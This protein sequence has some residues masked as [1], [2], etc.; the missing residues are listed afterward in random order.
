MLSRRRVLLGGAALGLLGCGSPD[1]SN[2][3]TGSF[4]QP[5]PSPIPAT[6]SRLYV[7]NAGAGSRSGDQLRLTQLSSEV[8][9][10]DDRPARAAGRQSTLS[11]LQQWEQLGFVSDPPNAVFQVENLSFPVILGKPILDGPAQAVTFAIQPDTGAPSLDQLPTSFGNC[12]LFIDDAGSYQ[13]AMVLSLRF[14][15]SPGESIEV[16]L[17]ADQVPVSIGIGQPGV[18]SG[19]ILNA[20]APT[21]PAVVGLFFN[22]VLVSCP[23]AGNGAQFD[24]DLFVLAQPGIQT[25]RIVAQG[26]GAGS[27]VS[28]TSPVQVQLSNVPTQLNWV[29]I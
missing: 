22:S 2:T 20:G 1:N 8:I 15:I 9:W 19:L 17:A 6:P 13:A 24:M 25:F 28:I 12:S 23:S 14:A 26:L 18:Q 4:P 3:T 27:Q 10:F 7:L 21:G 29:D 5:T 16:V 11:F